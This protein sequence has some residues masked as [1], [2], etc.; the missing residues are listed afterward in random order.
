MDERAT[1]ISSAVATAKSVQAEAAVQAAAAKA[2]SDERIRTIAE[3]L[4]SYRS[5]R[6]NA[7]ASL[8]DARLNEA[9]TLHL[10]ESLAENLRNVEGRL[11]ELKERQGAARGA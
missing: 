2:E 6:D 5:A 9:N 4:A 1:T 3:R 11:T 8:S 10:G 7:Y